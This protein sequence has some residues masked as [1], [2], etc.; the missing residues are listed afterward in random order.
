[1][2]LL[3]AYVLFWHLDFGFWAYFWAFALW[4]MHLSFHSQVR[5]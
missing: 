1:M 4:L 2:T 3:I 5:R